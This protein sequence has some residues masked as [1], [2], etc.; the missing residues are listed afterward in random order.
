MFRYIKLYFVYL[1]HAI[2]T[3]LQYKTDALIGIFS[4]I[5]SNLCSFLTIWMIVNSFGNMGGWN[6]W[7][8]GFLYGFAMLPKGLDHIFTDNL[9]AFGFRI[10]VEGK[11]DKYLTKP[12]NPLFLLIAEK[13]Q[14][15]GFGELII[16][17]VLCIVCGLNVSIE[18]TFGKI[19]LMIVAII[20]GALIYT[21][22]KLITAS[23]SFWTKR[24]GQIMSTIYNINDFSKYPI[25]IFNFGIQI[26]FTFII[27]FALCASIPAEV[28]LKGTWNPY[29]V[30]LIII[31]VFLL[32]NGLGLL[33]WHI[34]LKRYDST[35]S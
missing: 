18:V 6:M 11:F 30:S 4:F 16:G 26:V 22:I 20:F 32:L 28:L 24:S 14:P 34:G 17:L 19:L 31:G 3:H 5:V 27:P 35:G 7:E 8:L 15:E 1:S 9:W 12:V 2:Q 33:L 21:G 25:K 23:I 13:F 10:L 29:F